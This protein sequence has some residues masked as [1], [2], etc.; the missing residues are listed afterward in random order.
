MA[1]LAW[2]RRGG[3]ERRAA[4]GGQSGAAVALP[5]ARRDPWRGTEAEGWGRRAGALAALSRR[6]PGR[7]GSRLGA[8]SVLGGGWVREKGGNPSSDTMFGVK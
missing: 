7:A 8:D 2:A 4:P 6:R 1:A 5:W 3:A